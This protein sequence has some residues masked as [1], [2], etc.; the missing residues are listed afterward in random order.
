MHGVLAEMSNRFLIL[1]MVLLLSLI[2]FA[3]E[4]PD[5]RFAWSVFQK[6]LSQ[7]EGNFAFSPLGM[8][9]SAGLLYLGAR[10]ETAVALARSFA[11]PEPAVYRGEAIRR[12]ERLEA[13][14]KSVQWESALGLFAAPGLPLRQE[15]VVEVLSVLQAQA[16]TLPPEAKA[17]VEQINRWCSMQT[18]GLIGEV[19]QPEDIQP[20]G[21]L[22]C[23]TLYLQA[24][25]RMAFKKELTRPA[26]F[27]RDKLQTSAY[28]MKQSP[29][30]QYSQT[31]NWQMV[32]L[33]YQ[34]DRLVL[35][36]LLPKGTRGTCP[37]LD[38]DEFQAILKKAYLNPVDIFLPRFTV[39]SKS[40]L[41]PLLR[42]MGL[43]ETCDFSG[44]CTAIARVHSMKQDAWVQVDEEG[45][46]AAAVTKTGLVFQSVGEPPPRPEF[47][48]NHPFLFVIRDRET[49]ALL[50]S[51]RVVDPGPSKEPVEPDNW[52]EQFWSKPQKSKK[53]GISGRT[54]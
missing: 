14:R 40:N 6:L 34:G 3:E 4:S 38:W 33:P 30:V 51:G 10:G 44:I 36:A 41:L 27:F 25:W 2:G 47:R 54:E 5:D 43:P 39:R 49:G 53:A 20:G 37:P 1:F 15:Y 13:L 8:Q 26:A 12:R 16:L 11:F 7:T 46:K 31:K 42:E 29:D 9:R 18:H 52:M 21:L 23:D 28:M 48:A 35:H 45:A 19:C 24:R 22:L 32:E 17:A 50:F